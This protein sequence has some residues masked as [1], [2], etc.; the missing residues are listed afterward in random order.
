MS[1]ST[2]EWV[3]RPRR[4]AA[5]ALVLVLVGTDS[6]GA[7]ARPRARPATEGFAPDRLARLTRYLQQS[8]DSGAAPGAVAMIARHGRIVYEQAVGMADREAA[9]PMTPATLFR[10]ASQSK[11]VTSVA[12]MVLMEEGRLGLDDPVGRYIPAFGATTVLTT[13]DSSGV[14]VRRVE[15]ARRAITV[16]DL[17]TQTAGI[18]YGTDSLVRERYAAEG[19]G[20]AAGYGWYFA[21]KREP[22]CASAERLASLPFVAQPGERWVY[23]YATDVLGCVVERAAGTSLGEFIRDR[24]TG[25]LG[26]RDTRFCVPAAERGRLAAVY[27]LE[28]GRLVRAGDGPRGQGDYVQGPCVSQ[29]GGAG[30]VSTVGDYTRFLV[31]LANGG[32]VGGTRILSPASVA[33]MSRDQVGALYGRPGL[34]FGLGFEVVTDPGRAGRLGERGQY[35]WGGAYHTMYWVDP[36]NDLVAVLMTQ[37]LP[38]SG[39][40]LHDRFR[41]LVYQALVDTPGSPPDRTAPGGQPRR[42]RPR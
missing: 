18:S 24:I 29:S 15:R 23:G 3:V 38:A 28:A 34:G 27:A 31:M 39:S 7:Q 9:R 1:R 13:A 25:P 11:A 2:P 17:L 6:A 32:A 19:L 33:L 30:L 41:A 12:A 10:I 37:I 36:A 42:P 22:I 14:R 26:M 21:D 40:I 20:P 4:A 8:V 16:R 5:L 35:G